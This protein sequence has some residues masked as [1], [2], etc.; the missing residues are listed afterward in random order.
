MR[1]SGYEEKLAKFEINGKCSVPIH[2]IVKRWI[3]YYWPLVDN[4]IR[5]IIGTTS[6]AFEKDLKLLICH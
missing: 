2:A 3:R 4:D 5:Q 6:L 1:N